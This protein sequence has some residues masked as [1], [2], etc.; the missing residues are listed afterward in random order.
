MFKIKIPRIREAIEQQKNDVKVAMEPL[1]EQLLG[2]TITKI[3]YEQV[4]VIFES[5]D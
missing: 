5:F 1:K 4:K 3:T 2:S